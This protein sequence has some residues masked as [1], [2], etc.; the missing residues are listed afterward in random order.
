MRTKVGE[1]VE[2]RYNKSEERIEFYYKDGFLVLLN[3][4]KILKD[5]L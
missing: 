2:L 3:Q 4:R 5:M 1:I